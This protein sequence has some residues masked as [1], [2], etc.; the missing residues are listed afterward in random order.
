[1]AAGRFAPGHLGELTQQV[2]FEM[3]DAVLA[4]TRTAQRRIRDL[5]ARVVVYLLLAGSLFAELGYRQVWLRLVAGLDGLPVP[6]PTEA[7]LTKARHR[8]GPAPLRA[9]FDL[10]RGPA[11]TAGPVRWKGLLVCAIDATIMS[12]ADSPANLTVFTK[13]R[14][15]RCGGGSYPT[16]RVSTLLTRGTRTIIDAVFGPATIGEIAYAQRLP[17]SMHTGML[18]LADRYYAAGHLL[19][20]IADTGADLIVRARTGKTGPKLPILR[21]HRDGSY[22]S[23]FGGKPV[24]VID[25]EITITTTTGTHTGVYRLI[26]TLL[27]ERRHPAAALIR[28]YHERW[29]IETAYL[30][31]KS[32]ILGSRVLRARTPT[33]I[34]QEIYALLVTYQILRT[35][36]TDATNTVPGIDP[37]RASFTTALHAARDQLIQ[38]NGI[39]ADTIIDLAGRIGRLVLDNLLPDR[40]PRINARTVKRAIS[41]YNARGPNIDRRTYKTTLNINILAGPTLTTAP[42][43]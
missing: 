17:P 33:G 5:P 30:E 43:P 16:T 2:P 24:R 25:A 1:M 10:L 8:L 13:Q 19:A 28:L 9:L 32:S 14:G 26:T 20:A 22:R 40:R 4:E 38:A 18:I 31:L 23:A 11:A 29:E 21:R 39:I 36:M 42:E 41:K 12:V 37:D 7:A 35:A 3:V 15:G 6:D 34:T 27:D